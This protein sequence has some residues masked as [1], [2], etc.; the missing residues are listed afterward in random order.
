MGRRNSP[1]DPGAAARSFA[2]YLGEHG[3]AVTAGQAQS[4]FSY[5]NEWQRWR[6]QPGGEAAQE[7]AAR[8]VERVV[9][10]TV[11]HDDATSAGQAV[12]RRGR[13][14]RYGAN[15]DPV[16]VAA[17]RARIR[18]PHVAPLNELVD[19]IAADRGLPR[20]VM[21]YVDPEFGGIHARAMVMLDNAS[22][23]A[24]ASGLLS[25][26]N[27]DATACNLRMAYQRHKIDAGD[28]VAWNAVPFPA[29]R[30]NG[31]SSARERNE[32]APYIGEFIA[33]CTNLTIIV[34]LG[35]AANDGWARACINDHEFQV[36]RAPHPSAQ[37]IAT[38]AAAD[39]FE[40]A[41]A[42]LARLLHTP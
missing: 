2:R 21:S 25:L 38:R 36:I 20:N 35:R 18:E 42:H 4:F 8:D 12:T 15:A 39:L 19:Q 17:K 22:T 5:H 24:G 16:Y 23:K 30:P 3:I 14:G 40:E 34:L 13:R 7:K 10:A 31:G 41:I 37:G 33:R 29:A 27:D 28:V 1:D 32:R 6:N 9:K 11:G 26:D